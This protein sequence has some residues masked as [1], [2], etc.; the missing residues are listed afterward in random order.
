M[1]FPTN[2]DIISTSTTVL[3]ADPT[4]EDNEM[5][6]QRITALYC[7]LSNEDDLE[8]ESNSISN[9][10][11][12]LLKYAQDHGFQNTQF[13][14]DDGYTGTNFNRPAM[15]ELLS[16]VEAGQVGTIIVKDL[17]RFGRDYLQVGKY[18]EMEFPMQ[19]VRFIAINDGV[20][21]AKGED[22]FTPIRSLFNDFYAKDTSRKVRAVMRT[23][24]GCG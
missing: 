6:Q 19:N 18:L 10:R 15:Q 11:V 9:Q 21:S 1:T 12:I 5:D 24:R 2:H 4:K 16:M 20:D 23:R 14:V 8:G 3:S 17:S 22:D 13:F 7:R